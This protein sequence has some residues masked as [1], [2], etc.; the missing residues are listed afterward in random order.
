M[1]GQARKSR[2]GVHLEVKC[3]RLGEKKAETEHI[4]EG[5]VLESVNSTNIKIKIILFRKIK[6]GK[7]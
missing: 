7:I 2:N 6:N 3:S 1:C 5:H 4:K